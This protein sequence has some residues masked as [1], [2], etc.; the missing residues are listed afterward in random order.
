M[1]DTPRRVLLATWAAS[2]FGE[3]APSVHT[4][5]RM[6]RDRRIVPAPTLVG[7]H[8]Y[9]PPAATLVEDAPSALVGQLRGARGTRTT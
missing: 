4:L 9:V 5:R 1:S 3:D 2:Y 7:K 8:Y 6:V